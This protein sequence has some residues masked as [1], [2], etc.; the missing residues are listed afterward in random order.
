MTVVKDK[1]ASQSYGRGS[2]NYRERASYAVLDAAGRK[3]GIILGTA[4]GYMQSSTWTV[5]WLTVRGIPV[6]L[7]Y[8]DTFADAKTWA[9][10]WD[11]QAPERWRD[12]ITEGFVTEAAAVIRAYHG[13]NAAVF[14][15]F[16]DPPAGKVLWFTTTRAEAERYAHIM[17]RMGGTPRVITCDVTVT[18]DGYARLRQLHGASSAANYIQLQREGFDGFI[19]E[20]TICVFSRAQVR[21]VS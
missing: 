4:A 15:T 16:R 11:G 13:T 21:I 9:Q 8:A 14:D 2:D 3:V 10:A 17:A 5:S 6:G 20:D 7:H 18:R 12:K 19:E 1:P